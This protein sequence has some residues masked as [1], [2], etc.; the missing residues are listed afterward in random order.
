MARVTL[1]TGAAFVRRLAI[2]GN[3]AAAG[4]RVTVSGGTLDVFDTI[5][6]GAANH[7]M[8]EISGGTVSAGQV[9]LGGQPGA[10]AYTGTLSLTGGT[11]QTGRIRSEAGNAMLDWNGGTIRAIAAPDIAVPATLGLIGGSIDT[12]GFSGTFSGLASGAG[13]LTKLGAGTLAISGA[14]TFT[15][16]VTIKAGVVSVSSLANGGV[17]S[18]LGQSSNAAANLVLDG[19]T[20]KHTGATTGTD[21]LFTLTANGGTLDSSGTGAFNFTN[22]GSIAVSGTGARTLYLTGTA[23]ST[24]TLS[25]G[26]GDPSGGV[27][28]VTKDGAGRWFFSGTAKTYSGETTINSGTLQLGAANVLPFGAGKGD[29]SIAAGA[30]LDL[31]NNNLSINGLSGAGTVDLNGNGTRTFTLGNGD[32]S[33]TF[34][35]NIV[36]ASGGANFAL[37]KVGTGTQILGGTNVFG[38]GAFING[39]VLQF[40]LAAGMGGGTAA[41]ITVLAGA[42][43]AAGFAIDQTFLSRIAPAL[44]RHAALALSSASNL[45]FATPLLANV[46]LGSVGNTSYTGVLTPFA[47]TYR[48]GGGNGTLTLPNLNALTG[49]RDL[50]V[51]GAGSAVALTNTNDYTGTTTIAS[52][53]TLVQAR[54]QCR[55]FDRHLRQFGHEPGARRRH[56]ETQRRKFPDQ[57]PFHAHCQRRRIGRLGQRSFFLRYRCRRGERHRRP[58]LD[59]HGQQREYERRQQPSRTRPRRSHQRQNVARERW[60]RP[61]VHWRAG[62]DLQRRHDDSARHPPVRDH[63]RQ[64]ASLWLGQRECD[65]GPRRDPATRQQQHEPEWAEWRRHSHA[66]RL[67]HALTHGWQWRREWELLRHDLRHRQ[68]PLQREQSRHRDAGAER[69]EQLRGRHQCERRQAAHLRQP[70]RNGVNQHQWNGQAATRSQRPSPRHRA[71]EHGGRHLRHGGIQRDD[72]RAQPQHRCCGDL[73]SRQRREHLPLASSNGQPWNGTLQITN[74]NGAVSG[75]GVDRVFFGSNGSGLSG[76][77]IAA[78]RFLNPAGFAADAYGAQLLA[79]GEIVAAV[80]EP[81]SAMTLLTGTA[82]LLGLRRFRLSGR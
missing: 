40:N 44:G 5:Q 11:L 20:L 50:R 33:A 74:W 63:R 28:S 24:S 30:E 22:G 2:G 29:V 49:L 75:G 39:G 1:A 79:T 42:H 36:N 53:G 67:K 51:T 15:G 45:D 31:F 58:H 34:S 52:G 13:G 46:S 26:L 81:G 71:A 69:P 43:G 68:Q 73:R 37:T 65:R 32:A 17:A 80:P 55:Q 64:R 7:G 82:G 10:T 6:V 47:T 70:Q 9:L 21:R 76:P 77:Q 27:T 59:A 54:R 61:L 16:A 56:L 72:R 14:N 57:S 23:A 60:H 19:G 25:F 48:L 8:L 12:N 18:A 3:G 62:Q 4:E 66:G 38:R 35:G 41:N 78:V